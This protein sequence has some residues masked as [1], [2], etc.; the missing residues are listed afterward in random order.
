MCCFRSSI[1]ICHLPPVAVDPNSGITPKTKKGLNDRIVVQASLLRCLLGFRRANRANVCA[2]A[3]VDALVGIDHVDRA[4]ADRFG[5][6]LRSTSAAGD[7]FV[8]NFICHVPVLRVKFRKYYNT[9]SPNVNTTRSK[10]SIVRRF[11]A[12]YG[13][14]FSG[15]GPFGLGRFAP[16]R[17]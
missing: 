4:F 14:F 15:A 3:A 8:R 16:P 2:V 7:A 13:S 9:A 6:A 1:T 10:I 12:H 11:V 17:R 5:G